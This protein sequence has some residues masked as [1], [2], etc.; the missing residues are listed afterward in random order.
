MQSQEIF[1]NIYICFFKNCRMDSQSKKTIGN[2][3]ITFGILG[4]IFSLYL[5]FSSLGSSSITASVDEQFTIMSESMDDA[6]LAAFNAAQSIRSAK[7]S[8]ESASQVTNQVA[9][10]VTSLSSALNVQIMGFAPLQS[11]SESVGQ[12]QGSVEQFS[13]DITRTANHL[14]QN[15]ADVEKL[16]EDFKIMSEQL[17]V[18]GRKLT[19][20][21]PGFNFT[22]IG[23]Y[24]CV[25]H[26]VFIGVGIAL[27]E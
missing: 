3:V 18:V 27:K 14:E 10:V 19:G 17:E 9:G 1:R 6:S 24:L 23:I 15:A 11:A 12:V 13:S 25:L 5:L 16:G 20:L 8:L 21:S 2:V 26:L 7:Q 22:W 4:F